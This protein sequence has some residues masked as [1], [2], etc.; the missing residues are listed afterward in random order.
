MYYFPNWISGGNGLQQPQRISKKTN[1]IYTQRLF[2]AKK[3]TN[4]MILMNIHKLDIVD[5]DET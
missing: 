5:I 1:K 2:E 3:V 4:P